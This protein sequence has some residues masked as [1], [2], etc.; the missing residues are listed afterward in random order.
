MRTLAIILAIFALAK[1]A[2]VQWLYRSA[3][4]DVIV[5]AYRPRA[6]EACQTAAKRLA[7]GVGDKVWSQETVARLEIGQRHGGVHIWQVDRP[8][9]AARFRNPYLQLT[10]G[11]PGSQIQC[12]YDVL[13]GVAVPAKI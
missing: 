1:L 12:T 2:T 10:A 7:L 4:D 13:T 3:S 5:N 6:L 11:G 9:W 8:E